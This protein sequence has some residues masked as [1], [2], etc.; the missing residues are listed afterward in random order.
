MDKSMQ[1]EALPLPPHARVLCLAPHADDEL[2]GCGGT[3]AL[4]RLQHDPVRVVVAFDGRL[5]LDAGEV[6]ERRKREALRGGAIL[7][8][9]DYV[10]LDHPEGH[11]PTDQEL[12]RGA[13]ELAR[14]VARFVPDLVYVPWLGDAHRDHRS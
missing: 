12:E 2:L 9:S 1:P 13:D 7:G 4:H 5:G 10:F 11:V 14:E 6:A 3:L 8:L